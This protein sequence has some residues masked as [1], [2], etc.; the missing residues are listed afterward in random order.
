[1][2]AALRQVIEKV[3]A[4]SPDERNELKDL[5]RNMP[6]L[7]AGTGEQ[8]LARRLATEGRLT[9]PTGNLAPVAPVPATGKPLS[10]MI[11]EERR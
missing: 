2:T 7:S 6:E 11:I 9:L 4:L 8:A 5:M 1:M 3:K 10:E